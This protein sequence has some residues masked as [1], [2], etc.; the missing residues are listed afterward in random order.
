MSSGPDSEFRPSCPAV[1]ARSIDEILETNF[2]VVVHFWAAWNK[3]D[4][5]MDSYINRLRGGF[6]DVCFVSCDVDLPENRTLCERC[7]VTNI[8]NLTLFVSGERRRGIVGLRPIDALRK[9][10]EVH[11]RDYGARRKWLQSRLDT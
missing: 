4:F 6:A 2:A 3:H 9:K 8:P 10:L 11:L 1:T 5:Q 7:G